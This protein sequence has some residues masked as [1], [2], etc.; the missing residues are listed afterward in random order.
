MTTALRFR[1]KFLPTLA[2]LALLPLLVQ[3]GL[4]QWHKAEAKRQLQRQVDVLAKAPPV[5]L[6]P[7]LVSGEGLRDRRVMVRGRYER[8][9]QILLD[10][11]V[12]GAQV[13]YH[14]LTPLHIEGGEARVLVN[15]G[16]VPL[17]RSRDA[18]P[19]VAPPEGMVEVTGTI[20]Q[21]AGK[22]PAATNQAG[23]V[24]QVPDLAR[25]GAQVPYTLQPFFIR[26][27]PASV[28]CYVCRWPRVE[29]KVGMHLGYAVQWFGMAGV[30]AAFYLS[31]SVTRSD[32][33]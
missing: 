17:G 19:E 20:W 33:E 10:N 12:N 32:H 21:P 28:G 25:F 23:P 29:E 5:V 16:W 27:D 8:A 13:G 14:V 15:R 3:F 30:L 11:Q 24:W 26:L 1:P 18:L 2:T 22:Q 6:G 31:A 9:H 4:W 7:R